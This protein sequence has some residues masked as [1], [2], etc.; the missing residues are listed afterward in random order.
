VQQLANTIYNR[1]EL[2][3]DAHKMAASCR[4]NE[5]LAHGWKPESGF[6]TTTGI[7]YD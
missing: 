1:V 4:K 6:L 5:T 2:A 3:V 7:R